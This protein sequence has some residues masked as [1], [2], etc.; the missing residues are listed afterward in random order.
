MQFTCKTPFLASVTEEREIE[1]SSS[2]EVSSVSILLSVF[3]TVFASISSIIDAFSEEASV[4]MS[5]A[6]TLR[7]FIIIAAINIATVFLSLILISLSPSKG[8]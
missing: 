7:G 2:S 6:P 4:A 1:G 8:F 5:V 3:D